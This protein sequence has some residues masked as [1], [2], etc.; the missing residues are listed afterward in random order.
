MSTTELSFTDQV[1]LVVSDA[2]AAKVPN[3]HEKAQL[4]LL[5][6]LVQAVDKLTREVRRVANSAACFVDNIG[7][8]PETG[9]WYDL[10]EQLGKQLKGG[11]R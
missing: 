5:G 4:L 1:N 6:L 2:I 7:G 3:P 9:D 10:V 11:G 8:N